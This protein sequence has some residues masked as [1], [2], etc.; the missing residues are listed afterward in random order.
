MD[1]IVVEKSMAFSFGVFISQAEEEKIQREK[2]QRDHES[3]IEREKEQR[4]ILEEKLRKEIVNAGNVNT[5]TLRRE[6]QVQL[7]SLQNDKESMHAELERAVEKM[8][9]EMASER[10]DMGIKTADISNELMDLK[11]SL[12]SS[13]EE[14]VRDGNRHRLDDEEKEAKLRE[15][16][17]KLQASLLRAQ[18]TPLE[19]S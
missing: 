17:I 3:E 1:S 6:H 4:R 15:M 9:D 2:I 8:R 12:A 13:E 16:E 11:R 10:L 7:A 19:P 18:T 14:R 5:E